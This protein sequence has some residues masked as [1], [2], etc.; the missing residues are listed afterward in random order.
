M[1]LILHSTETSQKACKLLGANFNYSD[2]E[3]FKPY[4]YH[5]AI[6]KLVCVFFDSCHMLKLV[7]NYFDLKGPITY[8]GNEYIN[9]DYLKKL[10]NEQYDE[11]THCACKIK[12]RHI[13]F[14]NKKMKVFLTT[15][16]F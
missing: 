9:W 10:N 2:K 8:N 11:E 15:Q 14:H 7:R 12:N 13:Y 5:P 16:V 3:N 4:F 1:L 6:H